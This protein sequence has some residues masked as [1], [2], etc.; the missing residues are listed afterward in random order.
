MSIH[1]ADALMGIFGFKRVA[2]DEITLD[3]PPS[4]DDDSGSLNEGMEMSEAKNEGLEVVAW[5]LGCQTMTG[6]IGWKLS[7]NQSGA[8]VCARLKGDEYEQPL[9]RHSEALAGYAVRDARIAEQEAQIKVLQSDANSWQSGY[10]EGRRM[11]GKHCMLTVDQLRAE[12]AE[13]KETIS[14][15][16]TTAEN[17]DVLR[18]ELAN[19]LEVKAFWIGRTRALE[20]EL[21]AIKA[22][23]PV[24]GALLDYC[25]ECSHPE[26]GLGYFFTDDCVR[27]LYAAPVAKQVVMPDVTAAA[28]ALCKHH[29]EL[30]NVNADDQWNVYSQDFIADAEIVLASARLNAADQAEGDQ[31]E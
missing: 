21:A 11:G 22:Q 30:C 31:D 2:G 8:G 26:F 13:A 14:R 20:V 18:A 3:N 24:D 25:E 4:L 17:C 6:E 16:E 5:Q 27:P 19:Q 10:D 29:A 28:K 23:E 9:C 1:A 7:W 12:L 15:Y